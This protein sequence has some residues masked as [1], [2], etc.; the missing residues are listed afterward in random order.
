MKS[1]LLKFLRYVFFLCPCSSFD[2]KPLLTLIIM[3]SI[4]TKSTPSSSAPVPLPL[5]SK[6]VSDSVRLNPVWKLKEEDDSTLLVGCGKTDGTKGS[7]CADAVSSLCV[8]LTSFLL[9]SNI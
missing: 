3:S 1:T 8:R 6:L 7:C 4:P 9:H 2:L 5:R